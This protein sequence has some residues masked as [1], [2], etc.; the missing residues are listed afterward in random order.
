MAHRLI[1]QCLSAVV[2]HIGKV[3]SFEGLPDELCQKIITTL[4]S[5]N[6]L[7]KDI[8]LLFSGC[9]LTRLDLRMGKDA[10][11]QSDDAWLC[12]T[13]DECM[14]GCIEH[15]D[16]SGGNVTDNGV[17]G[18]KNL[19]NLV[20]LNV[21]QCQHL[22]GSFLTQLQHLPLHTLN[23]EHCKALDVT[24]S[25]LHLSLFS[26]LCSLNISGCNVE[27]SDLLGIS[28]LPNLAHLDISNNT[29]LTSQLFI[30]LSTLPHLSELSI[31]HCTNIVQNFQHITSL[32]S[33]HRLHAIGCCLTDESLTHLE[34]ILSLDT[35][36]LSSN[37]FTDNGM[38]SLGKLSNLSSLDLSNC[39]SLT[40]SGLLPL[41]ALEHME[42]LHVNFC[43]NIT[44]SALIGFTH[45]TSL[46]II[47][48]DRLLIQVQHRP[49]VLLAEDNA[50]QSQLIKRVFERYH[51]DVHTVSNGQMALDTYKSNPN[52]VL[53]LMD[54]MMPIM[55]GLTSTM[56]IR[57][58][59]WERGLKRT[60]IIM[61][62]ADVREAHRQVCIEAGCDDFM[63]KPLDKRVVD[64]ARELIHF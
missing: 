14:A 4:K 19:I 53:V 56:L 46:G 61:Q 31:N 58:Y 45:L 17:G 12:V 27:D 51:F 52:F 1:D 41:R 10:K 62:T 15:M 44:A 5:H 28:S 7:T 23:L 2:K 22:S 8:L 43:R 25:L 38:H 54:V 13:Q 34:P 63:T 24:Q 50:M 49:L 3:Q 29:A 36:T 18:L 21:S 47:G 33:L 39:I 60:P 20:H 59:E 42:F 35:L 16:L 40:D 32:S 6:K 55:D 37:N 64:R 11:E 48:C 57:K 30:T 26:S 9:K